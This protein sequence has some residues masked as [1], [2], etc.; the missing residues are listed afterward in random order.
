MK[1]FSSVIITDV[2]KS[3][4]HKHSFWEII[5][6]LSGSSNTTIGNN[7]HLVSDGDMYL[8]PPGVSHWDTAQ[9][10]FSDLIIYVDSLDFPESLILHDYNTFLFS[11]TNM[12]NRV[13][14]EKENN[15]QSVANSLADALFQYIMPFSLSSG[16]NDFVLKLK[17]S[18]FENIENPD[19]NIA[20]EIK[21]MGYHPDY[22]RRCFKAET[23]ETPLSYLTGLRIDKAKQLLVMPTLESI[24][25]ISYKCG[26]RD[27]FYFST[28]FKKNTG[29]SPMQYRKKNLPGNQT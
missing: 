9:N 3:T 6:R 23:R 10:P 28:C 7:N 12:I 19:F 1:V 21:E 15:Y 14:T 5:Y 16:N 27:S 29:L 17:N 13:M 26:F 22:V 4:P 20:K 8:T 18:M 2:C 11:L 25:T 24:E